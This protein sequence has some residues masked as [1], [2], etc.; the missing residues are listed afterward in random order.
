MISTCQLETSL[1]CIAL[2]PENFLVILQEKATMS[3]PTNERRVSLKRKDIEVSAPL[4]VAAMYHFV[5]IDRPEDLR[6]KLLSLCKAEGT[7]G[8]LILANEGINGTIAGLED[9]LMR[10]V[11]FIMALPGFENIAVKYSISNGSGFHHMRI[12]LKSEIVTMGK[13]NIDPTLAAG[14][15]VDPVHWN[16][17]ISREDV[18]VIDTRNAYEVHIGRFKRA[19]DPVTETFKDFP[20]WAETLVKDRSITCGDSSGAVSESA[21]DIH[22]AEE[23]PSNP[24]CEENSPVSATEDMQPTTTSETSSVV[25]STSASSLPKIKAVAMYCTGGIRCEKATVFMKQLGVQ[26]V[27]HLKG[28]ILK[29]LEEIPESESLWEGECFVFDERVALKHGLEAGSYSRCFA[30]KM[31]LSPA[32][33]DASTDMGKRFEEGVHCTYCV[34]T[35]TPAQVQRFRERQLQVELARKRGE[36]HVGQDSLAVL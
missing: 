8:T 1:A 17:L 30:C 33:T 13:P 11:K 9:G 27:Y 28:G 6:D 4:K 32:D 31:P 34:D 7:R 24:S 12:K 10:V 21:S 35:L 20:A 3:V 23:P 19:L 36:M 5:H 22:N 16:A 18:M 14:T 15:Y 29:Y 25:A 26:E 2:K